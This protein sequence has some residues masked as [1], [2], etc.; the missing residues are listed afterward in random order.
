[1]IRVERQ[2]E[3]I[4]VVIELGPVRGGEPE[5]AESPGGLVVTLQAP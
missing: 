2:G 3:R 5:L 4:R 1:M